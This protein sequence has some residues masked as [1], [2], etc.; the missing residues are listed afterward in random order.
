MPEIRSLS[1][2]DKIFAVERDLERIALHD[3]ERIFHF[4][5]C[6]GYYAAAVGFQKKPDIGNGT[7]C[8]AVVELDDKAVVFAR[9]QQTRYI[10]NIQTVTAIFTVFAVHKPGGI[11]LVKLGVGAI[12]HLQYG[13]DVFIVFAV[14]FKLKT[15]YRHIS[16]DIRDRRS[17]EIHLF[18]GGKFFAV[19]LDIPVRIEF[20]LDR[21]DLR[22]FF[23]SR[24]R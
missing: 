2:N 12:V 15:E 9:A 22:S 4:G 11:P 7:A 6:I 14:D 13:H 16:V 3:L 5:R 17:F 1:A 23:C 19:D 10:V 8:L 20:R 21:R 24:K 18:A